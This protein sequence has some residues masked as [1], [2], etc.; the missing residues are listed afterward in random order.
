MWPAW[1]ARALAV[2]F[3][4]CWRP[5]NQQLEELQRAKERFQETES[6]LAELEARRK[7]LLD[8]VPNPPAD[9]VPSG[10]EEDFVVLREVGERPSLG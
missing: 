4:N 10:G 6:K 3:R 7:A 2:L 5:T 8:R 1:P 9:E